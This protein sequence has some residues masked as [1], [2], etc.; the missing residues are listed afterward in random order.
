M[1]VDNRISVIVT[2]DAKKLADIEK[3]DVNSYNALLDRLATE[4]TRYMPTQP[5]DRAFLQHRMTDPRFSPYLPIPVADDVPK[6]LELYLAEHHDL[7]ED[8]VSVK[9]TTIRSYPLGAP[10]RTCSAT[11]ARSRRKSSTSMRRARRRIRSATRV[12]K[13]GVERTYED[14]L[15]GTPGRQTLEV[16]AKGNTVRELSH[17]R[18]SQAT[19]CT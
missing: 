8:V 3:R 6:P 19:T 7:F 4:I 11:S 17:I 16:D 18:R 1:L 13:T 5:I 12:G 2:V 9:Q 15:R 14:D 10:L